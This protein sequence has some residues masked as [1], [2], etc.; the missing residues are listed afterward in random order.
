MSAGAICPRRFSFASWDK[1]TDRSAKN[2]FLSTKGHE[3]ALRTPFC[4][5]RGAENTKGVSGFLCVIARPFMEQPHFAPRK[6]LF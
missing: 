6:S 2:T 3:G 4:P 5:R 1:H